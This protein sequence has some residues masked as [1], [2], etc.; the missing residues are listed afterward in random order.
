MNNIPSGNVTFLFTDIEGST[1]LAQKFHDE[2]R[3]KLEIHNSIIYDA[4]RIN[5][6]I[7]FKTIGDAFCCAFNNS[8]DAITAAVESQKKLLNQK[9]E[10]FSLKVRMGIHSGNAEWSGSDYM[11][12]ITLARTQRVMS[13]AYGNQILISEDALGFAKD[14][15]GD[16]IHFRDLGSRRL[17]DLIQP[18]K[19]FQIISPELPDV[20][21]P[22]KTL[23]ARPN[24]LPIQLSS[25]IGREN[26]ISE[27]KELIFQSNL[28]TLL[29]PGG[30]GKTRLSLQ[31]C[32][33]IIDEFA[34]GVWFVELASINDSFLLPLE[35][36]KS[37]GIKEQPGVDPEN[38]LMDYLKEKEMIIILDNCE[39]LID[40]CSRVAEK[41]LKNCPKLKI[42]ST[43][44]E[45]FRIRGEKIYNV[46]SMSFPDPA[47]KITPGELIQ[48]ESAR[49]FTE[50]ALQLNPEF[51]IN[52]ENANALS[53]ICFRLDGIPLAIELAAARTGI[54]NLI[55]LNEKLKDRFKFLKSGKRTDLPRQQTLK[56]LID[57]SYDLLPDE[58]KILWKRISV[59]KRGFNTEAAEKICSD[60]KI[61]CEDILQLLNNLIEKSIIVFDKQNYRFKLLETIREYGLELFADREELILIMKKH[62]LFFYDFVERLTPKLKGA[63]MPV[64]IN[65]LDLEQGN[66]ETALE[67]S[68][69]TNQITG[70]A[71]LI[72]SLGRYWSYREYNNL[73]FK[74]CEVFL[75]FRDELSDE[76][77]ADIQNWA[78]QYLS[79]QGEYDKAEEYF[80]K[81]LLLYEKLKDA[82]WTG[83]ML[84]SL[85]AISARKGDYEKA[86]ELLERSL[87]FK[88]QLNDKGGLCG[89]LCNLGQLEILTGELDKAKLRIDEVL[90]LSN[91]IGDRLYLYLSMRLAGQYFFHKGNF[92]SA[93]DYYEQAIKIN[94]DVDYKAGTSACLTEL[95]EI[96]INLG[97]FKKAGELLEEGLIIAEG[98]EDKFYPAMAKNIRG[99][100]LFETGN[101]TESEKEYSESSDL[102]TSIND[103]NGIAITLCGLAKIKFEMKDLQNSFAL[104]R[105]SLDMNFR[106]MNRREISI[107]FF[108]LSRFALTDC[109]DGKGILSV[110]Q[111][112]RLFSV[113]EI[114]KKSSGLKFSDIESEKRKKVFN[115]LLE[116]SENLTPIQILESGRLLT[117]EQ[118]VNIVLE[119]NE[120]GV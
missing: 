42:L 53:E 76:L 35:I 88:R 43:S 110:S 16:R 58:E 20:F 52:D 12:Y 82:S 31:V 46:S 109:N 33:E 30:T 9:R 39:H 49:L 45:L 23:D 112:I 103:K 66:I 79:N 90:G 64:Y 17:K 94:R 65:L 68:I 89:A 50:R 55:T 54:M 10:E 111:C 84:N 22:L 87:N 4:V 40:E 37:T 100:F 11:G 57:W 41:L 108:H 5:N 8:R 70:G 34:N 14:A 93:L 6:G 102:Y 104:F 78:A 25:F 85:G 3:K 51:R 26:D 63:E 15:T 21:P 107:L 117:I 77:Y 86:C 19:L 62:F 74:W 98:L 38:F 18:V 2:L 99:L 106:M 73:G 113:S 75:K 60:E 120:S 67:W 80:K 72:F 56:A 101:L 95:A 24:N 32:A 83:S 44:R 36:I 29:G 105:K 81:S 13:A 1:M 28:V 48:Y 71:R 96:L 47:K 92:E 59:F 119:V 27:I 97:E 115:S 116:K 61:S 114:I 7:V 118:A 91:E 69:E